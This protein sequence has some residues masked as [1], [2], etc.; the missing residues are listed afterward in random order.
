MI[1][2]ISLKKYFDLAHYTAVATEVHMLLYIQIILVNI[3]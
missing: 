1:M 2:N 3:L